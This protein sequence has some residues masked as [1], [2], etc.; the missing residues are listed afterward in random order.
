[1]L[2]TPAKISSKDEG[3]VK[4][5]GMLQMAEMQQLLGRNPRLAPPPGIRLITNLWEWQQATHT[6]LPRNYDC[7]L[8]TP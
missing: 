2:S 5:N 6:G 4:S 3:A 1:M 7:T 8:R